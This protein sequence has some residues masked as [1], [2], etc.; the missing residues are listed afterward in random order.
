MTHNNTVVQSTSTT[1]T[2]TTTSSNSK[3]YEGELINTRSR[4][5]SNVRNSERSR[6]VSNASVSST[7]IS[8]PNQTSNNNEHQYEAPVSSS[9]NLTQPESLHHHQQQTVSPPSRA[10]QPTLSNTTSSNVQQLNLMHPTPQQRLTIERLLQIPPESVQSRN[11]KLYDLLVQLRRQYMWQAVTTPITTT[12][13]TA[14]VDK[15][16]TTNAHPLEKMKQE[17]AMVFSSHIDEICACVNQLLED[18]D[19]E[20]YGLGQNLGYKAVWVQEEE[21]KAKAK[22]EVLAVP[23]D[24]MQD[25]DCEEECEEEEFEE[26]VEESLDQTPQPSAS[27]APIL[28]NNDDGCDED[29]SCPSLMEDEDEEE[30]SSCDAEETTQATV[31]AQSQDGSSTKLQEFFRQLEN[32]EPIPNG[33]LSFFQNHHLVVGKFDKKLLVENNVLSCTVMKK[34]TLNVVV[35][36]RCTRLKKDN[37]RFPFDATSGNYHDRRILKKQSL[38]KSVVRFAKVKV[39]FGQIVEEVIRKSTS[40]VCDEND[41]K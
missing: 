23:E 33:K 38:A 29:D 34:S 21:L 15:S 27:T 12:T 36:R 13:T 19:V 5:S 14:A 7:T 40:P 6:S 30:E 3:H 18:L 10:C 39:D 41:K 31:N 26:E 32:V 4:A 2:N 11:P 35:H 16:S 37:D 22:R 28:S 24:Q 17:D 9:T 25:E 8:Y 1:T 20:E